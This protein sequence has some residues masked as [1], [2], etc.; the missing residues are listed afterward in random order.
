MAFLGALLWIAVENLSASVDN[1]R[2]AVPKKR[3]VPAFEDVDSVE[4]KAYQPVHFPKRNRPQKICER[5]FGFRKCSSG[6]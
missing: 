4:R 2:R 1:Q 6:K 3:P 5:L